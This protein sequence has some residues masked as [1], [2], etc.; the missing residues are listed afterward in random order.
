MCISSPQDIAIL[1]PPPPPIAKYCRR[2]EEVCA[3]LV[4]LFALLTLAGW[5]TGSLILAQWHPGFFPMPTSTALGFALL[6]AGLFVY[7][8]WPGR[9]R[10]VAIAAILVAV[11][12]DRGGTAGRRRAACLALAAHERSLHGRSVVAG[13]AA[14]HARP[15]YT[16]QSYLSPLYS[17]SA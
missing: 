14:C 12:A 7:A 11:L 9:S 15:L 13:A 16:H 4:G 2:L 3:A 10:F 17:D 6:G 5:V 1:L 8:R